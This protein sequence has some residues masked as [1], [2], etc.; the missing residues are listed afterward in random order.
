MFWESCGSN[1]SFLIF[2]KI[3]LLQEI[4]IILLS[5]QKWIPDIIKTTIGDYVGDVG[6]T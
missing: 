3:T 6:D 2:K 4:K 1:F 5:A